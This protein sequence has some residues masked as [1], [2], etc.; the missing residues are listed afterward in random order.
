MATS[1]HYTVGKYKAANT[2]VHLLE[3]TRVYSAAN[4]A[5]AAIFHY[6]YGAGAIGLCLAKTPRK[7]IEVNR[8]DSTHYHQL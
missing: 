8:Q 6:T 1:S 7:H 4:P 2:E 3:P 5:L